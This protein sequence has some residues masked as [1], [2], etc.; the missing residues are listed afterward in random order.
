MTELWA[1]GTYVPVSF[2]VDEAE[3][4]AVEVVTFTP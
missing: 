2:T 1:E 3:A 4:S